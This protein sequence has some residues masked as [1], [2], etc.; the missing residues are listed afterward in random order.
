MFKNKNKKWEKEPKSEGSPPLSGKIPPFFFVWTLP[1]LFG[2]TAVSSKQSAKLIELEYLTFT[3]LG[4][5]SFLK[6]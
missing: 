2:I 4:K 5:G 6:K 3:W 1:F